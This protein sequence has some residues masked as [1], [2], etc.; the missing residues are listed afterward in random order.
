LFKVI[1]LGFNYAEEKKRED[2][3]EFLKNFP[4][5]PWENIDG[6]NYTLRMYVPT[7]W[8]VCRPIY[9]SA[10]MCFVPD[11]QHEWKLNK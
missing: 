2:Q 7:G 9:R 3:I 1:S 5:S 10:A 6:N 4:P 11:P 8:V